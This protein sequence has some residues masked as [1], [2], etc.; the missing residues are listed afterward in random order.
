MSLKKEK[1]PMA[2]RNAVWSMYIGES[3]NAKCFCCNFEPITKVN[4]ECGHI[5][6]E[7]NG[8]KIHLTNLRPIC[9]ACNKSIGTKNMEIFMEQYGFTKNKNWYGI[10]S[11]KNSIINNSETNREDKPLE[12]NTDSTSDNDS[13]NFIHRPG[14]EKIEKT[15]SLGEDS[16]NSLKD[17]P[18]NKDINTMETFLTQFNVKQ[19][20]QLQWMLGITDSTKSGYNKNKNNLIN[21]VLKHEITIT[22]IK[23]LIEKCTGKKYMYRCYGIKLCG[24]HIFF[25]TTKILLDKKSCGKCQK[26]GEKSTMYEFV[27]EFENVKMANDSEIVEF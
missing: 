7:K 18:T 26:C 19:L 16:Y 21:N 12:K 14:K 25:T 20:K 23:G 15:E 6:S 4:Y 10:E 17:K 24:C 27:N 2:V 13:D 3:Y 11:S 8:G 22:K 5:V 1:I 9:S